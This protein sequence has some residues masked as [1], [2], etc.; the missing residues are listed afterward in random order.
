MLG[1]MNQYEQALVYDAEGN[2]RGYT[3]LHN[4]GEGQAKLQTQNLWTEEETAQFT[5]QL[6]RL[7]GQVATLAHWP[8]RDDPEV[9]ALLQDPN[10][11][12]PELE[13]SE[14]VDEDQ[15]YIVRKEDDSIDYA[16]SVIIP[17][18]VMVPSRVGVQA[19]VRKALE[20]VAERR[21][22]G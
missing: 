9:L 1:H 15:S 22:N 11:E 16:A 21:A 18:T 10:W 20:T 17:K 13:P 14:E 6:D 5:E 12:P 4:I 3:V 19:R 2:F 8:R 7:N